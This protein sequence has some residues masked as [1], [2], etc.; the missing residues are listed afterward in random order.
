MN[1]TPL[2]Y[3]EFERG[4]G[5]YGRFWDRVGVKPPLKGRS[6]ADVGC[7]H[8]AMCFRL[9]GDGVARVVGIDTNAG[10][11]A[12][13][14]EQQAE[15]FPDRAGTVV[16]HH[17]ELADLDETMTFDYIVSKDTLEHVADPAGLLED[18]RLRLKPGGCLFL[19]FGPLYN[20]PQGDHGGA[21][22]PLPWGHLVFDERR[23]VARL[24]E[25]HDRSLTSLRDLGLNG[26]SYDA[27]VRIL[28]RCGLRTI[29]RTANRSSGS[30]PVVR[31]IYGLALALSGVPAL[32]EYLTINV[33]AVL[34][35]QS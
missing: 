14:R 24:N 10:V 27:Y 5:E 12:F 19:G 30:R 29:R 16:F 1:H 35:K 11:I 33:Y 13:A 8:G 15:R 7:G 2:A 23:L 3:S 28:S 32:R 21:E 9:A 26:L 31:L 22:V 34:Q 25:R 4:L 6:V 18:V 17:G 20:S